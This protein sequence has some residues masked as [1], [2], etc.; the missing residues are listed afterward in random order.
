MAPGWRWWTVALLAVF[1]LTH[2]SRAMSAR[3]CSIGHSN[4]AWN[5]HRVHTIPGG[6]C[7][8]LHHPDTGFYSIGPGF[9]FRVKGHED[10]GVLLRGPIG[11][12]E[13][14]CGFSGLFVAWPTFIV[15]ATRVAW[16]DGTGCHTLPAGQAIIWA[17]HFVLH[18]RAGLRAAH[19]EPALD[20][21][22]PPLRR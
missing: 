2:S 6:G 19:W 17:G 16:G 15:T 4:D 14:V 8:W 20:A 9:S 5:P 22:S 10:S 12:A 1:A 18:P 3:G 21:T 7:V 11:D 13:A